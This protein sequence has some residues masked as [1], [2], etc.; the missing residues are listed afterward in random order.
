MLSIPSTR[1]SLQDIQRLKQAF[2]IVLC[3][4][5]IL[6]LIEVIKYVLGLELY[7]FGVHPQHLSGLIGIATAPLIHGSFEHLIS[8]T[9]ALIILGTALVYGYPRSCWIVLAIIWLLAELGVWFTARPV[10]H[11]GASGLT[12]GVM[13]FVF[14]IGILRRDQLAITLSLLV[15]FLYGTMI[16]GVFP[17]QAGVS[18]ET[19][20]WG[21]ALGALCAILFRKYDPAPAVKRY[22]WE[23]EDTEVVFM[24]DDLDSHSNEESSHLDEKF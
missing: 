4:T 22:S 23:H 12:Y 13:A 17:H 11:F 14:V 15:F 5:L 3:F 8:N 21:G 16:W 18:F 6:W 20:L 9:P 19:H 1:S 7:K 2:S 10:Y 24:E